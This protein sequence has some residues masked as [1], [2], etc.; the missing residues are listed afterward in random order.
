MVYELL[1]LL[2]PF[3]S[4]FMVIY[5]P[6]IVMNVLNQASFYLT[7]EDKYQMV[8]TVNITCLLA[9]A[10]VY[11]GVATSLPS[12]ANIKPVEYYLIY[13]LVYPFLTILLAVYIQV[14]GRGQTLKL[15]WD[16]SSMF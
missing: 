15:S 4:I 5:L 6:L 7:T 8:I 12:T 16:L 13:N 3:L 9:L 2:K 10:S 11:M 1:V 14:K